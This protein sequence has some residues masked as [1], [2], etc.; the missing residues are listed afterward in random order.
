MF[1]SNS[2]ARDLQT[3]FQ[4]ETADELAYTRILRVVTRKGRIPFDIAG[5]SFTPLERKVFEILRLGKYTGNKPY[6]VETEV[7]KTFLVIYLKNYRVGIKEWDYP[8]WE[9]G[10]Y[11]FI[12]KVT[13]ED[14]DQF[15]A[16]RQHFAFEAQLKHREVETFFQQVCSEGQLPSLLKRIQET[17]RHLAPLVGFVGDTIYSGETYWGNNLVDERAVRNLLSELGETPPSSWLREH[18]HFIFAI[19]TLFLTGGAYRLEAMNWMQLDPVTLDAF[20]SDKARTYSALI[21]DSLPDDFSL[22]SLQGKALRVKAL[23]QQV[24]SDFQLIRYI[25][26]T[27]LNKQIKCFPKTKIRLDTLPPSVIEKCINLFP[28]VKVEQAWDAFLRELAIHAYEQDK[29]NQLLL[30][31]VDSGLTKTNSDFYMSRGPC[32]L[33]VPENYNRLSQ[34]DFYC[35]V[36]AREGYDPRE[37]GL[38]KYNIGQIRWNQSKRMQFNGWKFW[39]GNLTAEERPPGQYWFIP[40]GMPDVAI[41]ENML[42]GGHRENGVVQSIRSPGKLLLTDFST[43]EKRT[44]IGAYDMRAARSNRD[45]RYGEREIICTIQHRKWLG[46]IL[47][48]LA[49]YGFQK[50]KPACVEFFDQKFHTES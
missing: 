16:Y 27:S 2:D 5:F 34:Q 44:F 19:H 12:S 15:L 21:L 50:Q 23:E 31:L 11:Q 49:D 43:G 22:L 25:N 41:D 33:S 38:F 47:Q 9:E 46:I 30:V 42:H 10:S 8:N 29:I 14:W 35:A 13:Q 7:K 6:E 4:P 3:L 39:H 24:R 45:V 26:G 20:L 28:E 36:L 37:Y 18:Q 32:S 48:T 40:P 1:S 17:L